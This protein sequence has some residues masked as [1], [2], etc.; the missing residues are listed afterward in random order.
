MGSTKATGLQAA[1]E[2]LRSGL[3]VVIPTDTVYGVAAR[4]DDPAAVARLY[5]A[6]GRDA[7]KPLPILVS[8]HKVAETIGHLSDEAS[9]LAR[10]L[11]PG[12]LTIV[13]AVDQDF[14]S[15]ALG[16]ERTVGLRMPNQQLALSLIAEAG[17]SLAVSS[18]NR[19]GASDPLTV[20]DARRQLGD[21]VA[22]YIDGGPAPASRG[23]TV[24]DATQSQV[25]VIRE[26]PISWQEITA[27]LDG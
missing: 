7:G 4:H 6:K 9:K 25:R 12:P 15:A 27:A 20:E 17:G 26:G 14:R 1:L 5:E 8:S 24:V 11:W 21:E 23:S 22:V 18:A 10:S 19:S 2:A 13:T 3:L 16:G